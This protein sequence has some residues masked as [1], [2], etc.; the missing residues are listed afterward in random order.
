MQKFLLYVLILCTL[1]LFNS[2]KKAEIIYPKPIDTSMIGKVRTVIILGNSIVRYGPDPSLGWTGDW[3]LDASIQ[4]NDFVHILI[5]DLQSKDNRIIV[6]FKNIADFEFNHASFQYSTIDTLRNADM[7]VMKIGENVN[8]T[9]DP[10]YNQFISNYDKLI[11][12]LDPSNKAVK[13]IVDGF[14]D[15]PD[16]NN[17]IRNYALSKKYPLISITDLSSVSKNKGLAGHP[18]DRGMRLIAD[19][20]WAHLGNYF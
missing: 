2:C 17:D 15:H 3:G 20:I 6:K 14:W 16:V 7:I 19:R 18:N 12:Y 13:L 1:L 10:N 11:Q 8:F 9:A 4:D 5:R